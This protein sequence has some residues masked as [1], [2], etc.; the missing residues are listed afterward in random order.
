M[1]GALVDRGF[2]RVT[3]VSESTESTGG[4]GPAEKRPER[5]IGEDEEVRGNRGAASLLM[6]ICSP[7]TALLGVDTQ[8]L[9]SS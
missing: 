7:A 9:I 4:G 8:L 5:N 2:L 1:E 3:L 6:S